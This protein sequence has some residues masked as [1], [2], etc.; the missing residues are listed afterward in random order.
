MSSGIRYKFHGSHVSIMTE[1]GADSPSQTITAISKADPAVVS[2]TGTAVPIGGVIYI[3][4]VVGMTEVNTNAFIVGAGS[5]AGSAKLHGVDSTGYTTYVSGGRFDVGVWSEFCEVTNWNRTGAS[6]TQ[7]PATTICSDEE[8]FETGL[9]GQ[10]TLALSFNYAPDTVAAQIALDT[11]DS[12]GG[13]FGIRRQ[14][15]KN[16]GTRTYLGTVQQQSDTAGVGGLWTATANIQ[17]TGPY[18]YQA[19]A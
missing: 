16:G 7:I 17:L 18:L 1:F 10:G 13:V 12:S 15:P 9:P 8:E 11:W 5:T 6:K 3:T 14:L 4:G 2:Y 19:A